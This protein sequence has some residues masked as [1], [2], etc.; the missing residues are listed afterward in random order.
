MR[1]K[2]KKNASAKTQAGPFALFLSH[3]AAAAL[4]EEETVTI[5]Q[6]EGEYLEAEFSI[7]ALDQEGRTEA[8]SARFVEAKIA[9]QHRYTEQRKKNHSDDTIRLFLQLHDKHMLLSDEEAEKKAKLIQEAVDF[10]GQQRRP[11]GVTPQTYNSPTPTR[12]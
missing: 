8:S 2:K 12:P 6:A 1:K 5:G 7:M 11:T 10:D 9:R 4:A 3:A